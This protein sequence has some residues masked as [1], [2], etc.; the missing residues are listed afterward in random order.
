MEAVELFYYKDKN[1][2][3]PTIFKQRNNSKEF[4]FAMLDQKL[5][6]HIQNVRILTQTLPNKPC[7]V[8]RAIGTV[9]ISAC[10][11]R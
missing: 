11:E 6:H 9:A 2:A 8:P 10:S 5:R 1:M 3:F 7:A 4:S